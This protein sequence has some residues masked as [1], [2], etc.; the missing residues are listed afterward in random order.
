MGKN[1]S[2]LERIVHKI[3]LI[4]ALGNYRYGVSKKII[5]FNQFTIPAPWEHWNY[6]CYC[7]CWN[8]W[9]GTELVVDHELCTAQ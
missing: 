9:L 4:Y 2:F 3:F 6:K 5:E 8:S 7:H 1:S